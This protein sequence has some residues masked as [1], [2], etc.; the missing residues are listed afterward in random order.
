MFTYI[1]SLTPTMFFLLLSA[2]ACLIAAGAW[3]VT[4]K[5]GDLYARAT[6]QARPWEDVKK[7]ED[8]LT[9]Y[10]KL[11]VPTFSQKVATFLICALLGW[12]VTFLTSY[13]VYVYYLHYIL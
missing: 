4:G 7:E 6:F 12:S 9:E 3:F 2:A 1:D 11:L 13:G 5:I 8:A 10:K